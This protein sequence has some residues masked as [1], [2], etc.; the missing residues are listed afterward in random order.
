MKKLA[1]LTALILIGLVGCAT[2][3]IVDIKPTDELIV[4]GQTTKAELVQILGKPSF[5]VTPEPPETGTFWVYISWITRT[6]ESIKYR[7]TRKALVQDGIVVK[8]S[9]TT[10]LDS[11]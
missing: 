8:Y 1:M 11:E 4:E 3:K 5:F 9:S 7:T 10:A 2:G 6:D